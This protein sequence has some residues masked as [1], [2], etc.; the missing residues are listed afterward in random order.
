MDKTNREWMT[1]EEAAA[2]LGV[3]QATVA[4]WRKDGTGP[5]SHL[6]GPATRRYRRA[7]VEDW[8]AARRE[9]A[10]EGGP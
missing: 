6:L 3:A 9:R 10:G 1:E 4:R 8:A 2:E 7:D 5:P